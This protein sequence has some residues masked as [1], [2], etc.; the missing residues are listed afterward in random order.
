M[1]VYKKTKGVCLG[2]VMMRAKTESVKRD[3]NSFMVRHWNVTSHAM[4][5]LTPA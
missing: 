5:L 3:D 1:Y 4:L 2:I